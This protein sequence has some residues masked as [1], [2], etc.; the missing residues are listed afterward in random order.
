MA[1]IILEV[2]DSNLKALVTPRLPRFVEGNRKAHRCLLCNFRICQRPLKALSTHPKTVSREALTRGTSTSC[3]S[4][5][6]VL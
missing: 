2:D 6:T 3:T 5:G 1:I 4:A